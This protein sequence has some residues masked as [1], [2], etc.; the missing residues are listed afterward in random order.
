M[1]RT[2]SF[3]RPIHALAVVVLVLPSYALQSGESA[4]PKEGE[5]IWYRMPSNA[6][7]Y[8]A[9]FTDVGTDGVGEASVELSPDSPSD[10]GNPVEFAKGYYVALAIVEEDEVESACAFLVRV[11]EALAKDRAKIRV[12]KEVVRKISDKYTIILYQ[13]QGGT[14]AELKKFPIKPVSVNLDKEVEAASAAG[15]GKTQNE[16]AAASPEPETMRVRYLVITKDKAGGAHA[17]IVVK[18]EPYVGPPVT[19]PSVTG[20]QVTEPEK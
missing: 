6:P 1:R 2:K 8:T 13:P 4:A 18:R 10:D 12:S 14:Q 20:P 16:S 3:S 7:M 9:T 19:R 17:Q 15:A 11:D 5:G